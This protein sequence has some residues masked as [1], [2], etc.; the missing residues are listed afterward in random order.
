MENK[1][2]LPRTTEDGRPRISYSQLKSWNSKEAFDEFEGRKIS[3]STG[4]ILSYF[5]NYKFPPSPMSV[6]APFGLK[7]EDYICNKVKSDLDDNEMAILDTIKPLGIFQKLVTI[8]FGDFI[9]EGFLDDA[10]EDRSILR[11]YKTASKASAKQYS[12]QEYMQL[13]IYALDFYKKY[14]LIPKL[15]VV[16]IERSGSHFKMP[17]K[18]KDTFTINRTTSKERLLY[19]ES[20]VRST[21]TDISD[22]YKEFLKLNEIFIDKTI[23]Y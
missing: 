7:V 14:G 1:I 11:D 22:C 20:Y 17:L 15:E 23:I 4:Y 8:D 21:V 12:E 16:V 2:I 19:V 3:G 9:L 5:L 10:N 18:V 6:Y 13:D